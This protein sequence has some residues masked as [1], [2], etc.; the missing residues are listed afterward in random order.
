[1]KKKIFLGLGIIAL[2]G[3]LCAFSIDSSIWCSRCS[4]TGQ[5]DVKKDCPVCKGAKKDKFGDDCY[6]CGGRGYVTEKAKCPDCK[7]KGEITDP[8]PFPEPQRR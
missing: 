4:G 8:V 5:I 3:V 1:M 2:F 7:G 6:N